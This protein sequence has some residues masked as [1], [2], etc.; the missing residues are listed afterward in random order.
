[1]EG[2]IRKVGKNSSKLDRGGKGAYGSGIMEGGMGWY[3]VY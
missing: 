2:V 3:V 1:M